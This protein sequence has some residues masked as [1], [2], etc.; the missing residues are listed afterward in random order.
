MEP[1]SAPL[2]ILIGFLRSRKESCALSLS[3][4]L[5]AAAAAAAGAAK[6]GFSSC[7]YVADRQQLCY[8]YLAYLQR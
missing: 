8:K 5:W 3:L 6:I 1:T 7:V 4:S 2:R